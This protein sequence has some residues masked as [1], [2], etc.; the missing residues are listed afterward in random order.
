M[1]VAGRHG[2]DVSS[3]TTPPPQILGRRLGRKIV[4]SALAPPTLSTHRQ[5]GNSAPSRCGTGVGANDS[6]CRTAKEPC[7]SNTGCCAPTR[8]CF[9]A[10][11]N[12]SACC[13][14]GNSVCVDGVC[15]PAAGVCSQHDDSCA[16][17]TEC[18]R[19]GTSDVYYCAAACGG[20]QGSDSSA[21]SSSDDTGGSGSGIAYGCVAA[22]VVVVLAGLALFRW[23]YHRRQRETTPLDGM[24]LT[25]PLRCGFDSE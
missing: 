6:D 8:C 20:G 25:Q 18:C 2:A 9:N 14:G 11:H 4:A 17:G 19:L 5:G 1:A 23:R 12:A 24:E 21:D 3:S 15:K 13:T 7:C 22:G 16:D 10:Q